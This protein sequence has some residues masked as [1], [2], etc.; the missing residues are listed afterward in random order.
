MGATDI[1]RYKIFTGTIT[2]TPTGTSPQPFVSDYTLANLVVAG[3]NINWYAAQSQC[4]LN[5]VLKSNESA[6]TVDSPLPLNTP[7]VNGT[8]YYATQ[9]INGIE[10]TYRL[11]I[12]V[13]NTLGVAQ[14]APLSFTIN[15]PVLENVEVHSEASFNKIELYSINGAKVLE[16]TFETT[17]A[18]TLNLE[19][20]A[21]GFYILKLYTDHGV[22]SNKLIKQ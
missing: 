14:V 5:T 18:A 17:K 7:L 12:L 15:N 2:P 19:K 10:S 21:K 22:C 11:P 4:G 8:T 9:T 6:L 16:K 1:R 3:A 20:C 13:T